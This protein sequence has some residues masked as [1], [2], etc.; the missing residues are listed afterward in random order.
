VILPFAARL[1]DRWGAYGAANR[2]IGW[3]TGG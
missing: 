3:S 2:P 1:N